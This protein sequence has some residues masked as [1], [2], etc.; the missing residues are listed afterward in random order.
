MITERRGCDLH[1]VD[2]T[3]A[4][5]RLLLTSFV[6]PFD[7]DRHQRLAAA[8]RI[9]ADHPVRI[10]AATAGDWLAEQLEV[11]HDGLTVVWQSITQLYWPAA[12]VQAVDALVSSHGRRG[13]LARVA[14][15]F[16]PDAGAGVM[17]DLR[18]TVLVRDRRRQ[19][20][21]HG[22][23]PLS[24]TSRSDCAKCDAHQPS[25]VAARRTSALTESSTSGS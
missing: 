8:L 19:A 7:I 23:R 16:P 5:G 10:D 17:P 21:N 12:E 2:V 1:P 15:E 6:W 13:R 14:M 24:R 18:T 22:H 20:A 25:R 9:A 11:D 4:E 3:A